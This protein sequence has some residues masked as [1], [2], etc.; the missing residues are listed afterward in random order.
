MLREVLEG[1]KYLIWLWYRL[2][3]SEY[4]SGREVMLY[5]EGQN[6]MKETALKVKDKSIVMLYGFIACIVFHDTV[7]HCNLTLRLYAYTVRE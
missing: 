4:Q 6:P 2:G 1:Q 3:M 5:T 7:F